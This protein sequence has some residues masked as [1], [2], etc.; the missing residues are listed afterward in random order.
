M[1]QTNSELLVELAEK[2]PV[3]AEDIFQTGGESEV[4]EILA[5]RLDAIAVEMLRLLAGTT[6]RPHQVPLPDPWVA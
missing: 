2:L 4:A 3:I 5:N 1:S 6:A